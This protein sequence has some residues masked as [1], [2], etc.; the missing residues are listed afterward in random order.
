MGEK[1]FNSRFLSAVKMVGIEATS[2]LESFHT[3]INRNAL[4]MVGFSYSGM[5]TRYVFFDSK[6]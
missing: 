3:A 1:L 4:K 6:C 5:L 2:D